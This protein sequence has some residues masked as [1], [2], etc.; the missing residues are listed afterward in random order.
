MSYGVIKFLNNSHNRE[1][2]RIAHNLKLAEFPHASMGLKYNK[3][4]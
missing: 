2:M 4:R 3:I 1:I